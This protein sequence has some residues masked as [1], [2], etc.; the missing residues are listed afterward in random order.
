[1][2]SLPANGTF[3]DTVNIIHDV[4]IIDNLYP[5]SA[6]VVFVGVRRKKSDVER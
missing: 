3:Y 1:M 5:N 6:K 4:I 2:N